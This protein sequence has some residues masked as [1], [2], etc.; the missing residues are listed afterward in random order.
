MISLDNMLFFIFTKKRLLAG[1]K[2]PENE[3]NSLEIQGQW[4]YSYEGKAIPSVIEQVWPEVAKAYDKAH[5]AETKGPIAISV[6]FSLEESKRAE[7]HQTLGR[8]GGERFQVYFEDNLASSFIHGMVERGQLEGEGSIVLE[9][10]DDYLNLWK[11]H[12]AGREQNSPYLGREAFSA[13]EE[14]DTKLIKEMGPS[15]GRSRLMSELIKKFQRAGLSLN[16]DS[17]TELAHQL[18]SPTEDLSFSL[19]HETEDIYLE[20]SARFDR[21]NYED[22]YAVNRDKLRDFLS[23][24]VL[25]EENISRVFTLGQFF[26]N[27]VMESFFHNDLG[28]EGRWVKMEDFSEDKEFK[29]I[30]AGLAH[31]VSLV[32]EA[33][34]HKAEL[35]ALEAQKREEEEKKRKLVKAELEAKDARESLFEEIRNTCINPSLQEEYEQK[36]IPRGEQLGIPDLVIKWNISEI[37]SKISLTEEAQTIGIIER[38]EAEAARVA[39]EQDGHSQFE[40]NNT[41]EINTEE[42]LPVMEDPREVPAPFE[43]AVAGEKEEKAPENE[44]HSP[45]PVEIEEEPEQEAEAQEEEV[46]V[47]ASSNGNGHATKAAE[48]VQEEQE[49]QAEADIET[50]RQDEESGEEEEPVFVLSPAERQ[51]R[52]QGKPTNPLRSNPVIAVKAEEAQ[53]SSSNG[54]VTQLNKEKNGKQRFSLGDIFSLKSDLQDKEFISKVVSFKSD[55]VLQTLRLFKETDLEDT[56]RM[57]AF[58]KLHQKEKA[59]YGEVSE[60]SEAKEG[61]YYYRPFIERNTLKNYLINNGFTK[62]ERVESLSSNELKFILMVF[63]EVRS[64]PQPHAD[65]NEET[66]IVVE[67][68]KLL[69]KT[70][71]IT[72]VGFT[73][74]DVSNNEMVEA[75]HKAFSKVMG[76]S[77]YHDFRKKFQL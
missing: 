55:S 57:E 67:K 59:F 58:M 31:R 32:Q 71:E 18:M 21:A 68:R 5:G 60:I 24:Q 65:L 73:S 54:T 30:F 40:E 27:G 77:F 43:V 29:A 52:V 69:Q 16:L 25:E 17:Q 2:G 45:T 37:L 48:P 12:V 22:L 34:A 61:L 8:L 14:V 70:L 41:E 13:S 75:T 9:A 28:L 53:K 39:T 11:I 76:E 3:I 51:D 72:F 15:T 66:I 74:E 64:L 19:R 26:Q 36:F 6:P 33:E 63:K 35:E 20:G 42:E 47:L 56:D 44:E 38:Q 49:S 46:P 23:R 50:E 4:Q 10:L 1:L 7:I 62:K